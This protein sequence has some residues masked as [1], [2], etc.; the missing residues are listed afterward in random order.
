MYRN[1]CTKSHYDIHLRE[2]IAQRAAADLLWVLCVK[3]ALLT[4][5]YSYSGKKEGKGELRRFW[6]L[7]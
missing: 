4:L 2:R 5:P 7:L 3:A 1:P 6:P